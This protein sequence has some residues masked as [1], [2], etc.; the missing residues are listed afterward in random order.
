MESKNGYYVDHNGNR[1]NQKLETFE[2]AERKSRTLVDC[3][4]CTDCTNCTNCRGCTYCTDCTDCTNCTNCT[5]CT[6]CTYCTHCTDCTYCTYCTDC[7]DCT[8]CTYCTDCRGCTHCMHCMDY[9]S[10]PMRYVTPFVGSRAGQT[11]VYWTSESDVQ[12]CCGCFRGNLKQFE[13]RIRTTHEHSVHLKPYLN[14]VRIINYLIK[15]TTDGKRN[16]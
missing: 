4:D 5:N 7:T 8:N 11:T 12:V 2:S 6:Y 3:T 16:V 14:Q 1:W 10:N 13:E 9:K 15:N